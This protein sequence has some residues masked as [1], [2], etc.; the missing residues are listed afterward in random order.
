MALSTMAQSS[1][2]RQMGPSL[3]MLQESAMAPVRG[4]RPKVGRKPVVPQRVEGDEMDPKVSDPMA[5]ATQPAA[6]ADADPADDPLDPCLVFQ[7]FRVIPP[8]HLSPCARAPRVSL[9]TRTAPALSRRCTTV[10]SSSNFWSSKPPA[11]QVVR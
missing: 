7:G 1:T 2:A 5:K 8:N 10:A 3:S 11:P 9:A 4:T 6:V